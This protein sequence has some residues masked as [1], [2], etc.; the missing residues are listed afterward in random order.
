MLEV[1]RLDRGFLTE[2]R[3]ET[4]VE[5]RVDGVRVKPFVLEFGDRD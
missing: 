4:G 1:L 3:A 2:A 5:E